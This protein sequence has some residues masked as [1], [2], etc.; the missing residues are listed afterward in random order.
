MTATPATDVAPPTLP[1][2]PDWC[3]LDHD[4]HEGHELELNDAD[5]WV[6]THEVGFGEQPDTEE[7]RRRGKA[8]VDR[9]VVTVFLRELLDRD[10]RRTD[11]N[12][13]LVAV[14]PYT[15]EE[16]DTADQLRTLAATMVEAADF[17]DA[18]QMT[19]LWRTGPIS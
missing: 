3:Q 5:H 6:W 13:D 10:G 9:P 16:V 7:R 4:D 18:H 17:L 11:D 8:P 1:A 15:P 2:C 14:W 19:G 12:V